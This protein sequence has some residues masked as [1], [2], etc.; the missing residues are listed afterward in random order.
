MKNMLSL[1]EKLNFDKVDLTPPDEVVTEMAAELEDAT[2]SLVNCTVSPYTG[3]I[4]SY[5]E[6]KTTGIGAALDVFTPRTIEERIDIQNEL[7]E[8]G[9]TK[10][11]FEVCLT[12]PQ[13]HA[14]KFR[15][16]FIEYDATIYPV[17]VVLESEV[18]RQLIQY[19]NGYIYSFGTRKDFQEFL[20]NVIGT[21]KVMA[22]LQQL[23]DL[24]GNTESVAVEETK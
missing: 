9:K 17:T 3:P 8:I 11:K 13:N 20:D 23:I 2:N 22:I 21:R 15:L 6:T 10:K 7:G 5:T 18:A 14:Y 1:K 16:M 12:T 4:R 24:A 19:G